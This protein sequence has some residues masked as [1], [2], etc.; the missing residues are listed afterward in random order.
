MIAALNNRTWWLIALVAAAAW[1]AGLGARHLQHPDE[2]RYGEIAREMAQS[3]DWITPRL[4][5]LKYFEKPPL[6]YWLNAAA[7]DALGVSDWSARLPSAVAGFLAVI[8]VGLTAARLAGADAGPLAALVLA[9]SVWHAGLAHLLTVDAVL[10]CFLAIAL[11]C[12]LLA[13]RPNLS[14]AAERHWMLAAYAAA[15]AATLTKGLVGVAI[16]GATLVLYSLFTR[17]TGPWRRLHLVSGLPIYLAIAAPW[18]VLVS[19]ANPE[20]AHFFFIHEHVD[21]FLTEEHNRGGEW[22]Y[23]VPWFLLGLMPWILV[24]A[25]TLPR[26]WREAPRAANGFSWERF[27]LVWCGFIFVFFSVSG[28][29]LPS[30]ILPMFP[31]LA[32]VLGFELTRLTSRALMW[33]ALPLAAGGTVGVFV[34]GLGWKQLSAAW[35]SEQTPVAIYEAFGPWVLAAVAA[36]AAGG[37]AAFFLFRTGSE[38]AKTGGIAALAL[39]SLVGLQLAAVGTEAFALVRSAAPILR[40]A[41][42]A[43]RQPLDPASPVYQ[44]A[45]Y[46]QTLPFYLGRP[47][48]LVEYR[49]EMSLGLAAEPAK[50]YNLAQWIEAWSAAPQAY[51]MM[52]IATADELAKMNVPFRVLAR[53]PRRVFVTRR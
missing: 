13:Q 42:R 14:R 51:A 41:E 4:N 39:T 1:F 50:G 19:R 8:A 22:W 47:T 3:G 29:K 12:F 7:F 53:D 44:V 2:G 17:D 23:F 37:V 43:N 48:P 46:D 21:R 25:V 45:S 28:S 27:C 6:Q 38:A 34:V 9:G 10:S 36:Y 33:I 35:A 52:T 31:A 11:C 32:L 49:D 5:D 20:F 30:Y 15:A 24:W 18:F 40:E 26:S 16:P